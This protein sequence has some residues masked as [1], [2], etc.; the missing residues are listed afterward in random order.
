MDEERKSLPH[1]SVREAGKSKVNVVDY[2]YSILSARTIEGKLL[3]IQVVDNFEYTHAY[4]KI[5]FVS[6]GRSKKISFSK[7]QM[8]FPKGNKLKTDEGKAIA[9]HFFANHELL[10]IEMMA[11]AILMFPDLDETTLKGLLHTISDEQKHFSLYRSRLNDFGHEFGDYPL[12][13]FFWQ[14]MAKI[15]SFESFYALVAL[16]FEQA[17][18]DFAC[19]YRDLFRSLGDEK[20]AEI[21]D[22]VYKD[23][24]AHVA[25]G[26]QYL[27]QQL[28]SNEEL[29]DYYLNILPHNIT[30]NR[31]KGI[32]FDKEGRRRSGLS[33]EF[34][35]NLAQYND[36]FKV[37]QRRQW[38]Q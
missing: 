19:H 10:A 3:P 27:D 13:A 2:A 5:I 17:N 30:A 14:Q 34:V 38:K 26:R 31:A 35:E 32:G 12:N 7:K 33:Q 24:I 36:D 29:W 37:T 6:P 11:Q 8:K 4:E 18:L 20:T 15:D 28:K 1:A 23:E 25:R 21:F 16:T 9:L 22:V